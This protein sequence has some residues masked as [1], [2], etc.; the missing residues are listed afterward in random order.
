MNIVLVE[1][2]TVVVATDV[3][4]SASLNDHCAKNLKKMILG[5]I[6]IGR[7]ETEEQCIFPFGFCSNENCNVKTKLGH[8]IM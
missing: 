5:S 6:F 8:K 4:S 3:R 7:E 1:D 2:S